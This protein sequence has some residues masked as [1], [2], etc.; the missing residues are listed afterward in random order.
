MTPSAPNPKKPDEWDRE[1]ISE[2]IGFMHGVAAHLPDDDRTHIT[3]SAK[4]VA[5]HYANMLT[6]VR[7][8]LFPRPR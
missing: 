1:T 6:R 2:A 3:P 4:Y 5:R 7:E 8:R